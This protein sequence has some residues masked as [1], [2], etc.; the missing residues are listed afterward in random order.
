[1]PVL[2]ALIEHIPY[3]VAQRHQG[4]ANA[5]LSY[6]G[7]TGPFAV[8]TAHDTGD[9]FYV[10]EATVNELALKFGWTDPAQVEIMRGQLEELAAR[11]DELTDELA[12][13]RL[14]KTVPLAEVIDFI[15][16]RK[17]RRPEP[18]PIAS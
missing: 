14:N 9:P 13:E 12:E 2:P 17:N 4:P 16:A 5:E 6:G 18:E 10:S 11:V 3:N 8:I 1:M 7:I 15:E